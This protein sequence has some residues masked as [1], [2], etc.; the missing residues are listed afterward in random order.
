VGDGASIREG[1]TVG[2]RS[3]VGRGVTLNYNVRVG[4]RVKIMDH[5]WL[6]GN[7]SV[8]DGAFLSGGVLTA[9]DN[10]MG[11]EG[12][13]DAARRG[14]VIG[15][16]ARIGA[17]AVLLPSLRIGKGALVA[18]GAVVTRGVPPGSRVRGCPARSY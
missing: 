17:G 10:S 16:G 8:G 2:A 9:N 5:C 13:A 1:C 15:P 7:M 6:A 3:V 4:D 14:P 18:A 12:F 11:L